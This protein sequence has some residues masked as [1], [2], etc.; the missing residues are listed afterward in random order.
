[1]IEGQSWQ[2]QRENPFVNAR[3]VSTG[4]FQALRIPLVRGRLFEPTDR[5]GAAPVVLIS[6]ATAARF[7]PGRDP[8]GA[9]LRVGSLDSTASPWHTVVGIVGDVRQQALDARPSLDLYLPSEQ[10]RTGS[11]YFLLRMRGDPLV[12]A[13]EA[14][15][16]V[17]SIDPNQSFFDV[18][19]MRERIADRVWV[20][21]LA[22]VLISAFA[23][24]A[25]L[26]AAIGVSAVLAYNVAQRTRELGIRQALGASRVRLTREILAEGLRF[27]VIGGAIGVLAALGL[28]YTLRNL[29]YG[30]AVLDPPTLIAVPAIL[31]IAGCVAC[32]LPARRAMRITPVEALRG[33]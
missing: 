20:R 28:A 31:L 16:I 27:I 2:Q 24:L 17:W 3:I 22:G 30:I 1:M 21:R 9:R 10:S 25:S 11:N 4:L 29:L 14:P 7:W 12:H 23:A 32:W 6:E 19:T 33:G 26:L 5:D 13:R 8:I 15:E 18:R